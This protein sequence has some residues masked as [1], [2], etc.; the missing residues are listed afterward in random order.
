MEWQANTF[1]SAILMPKKTVIEVANARIG[2][3]RPSRFRDY[4]VVNEVAMTF[5]VSEEAAGIRLAYLGLI[6]KE[7]STARAD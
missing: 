3:R 4:S 1:S 7:Y 2:N 6:S 5:N